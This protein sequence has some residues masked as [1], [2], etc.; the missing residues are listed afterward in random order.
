[1]TCLLIGRL[2]SNCPSIT[3]TQLASSYFALYGPSQFKTIT[4]VVKQILNNFKNKD[5]QQSGPFKERNLFFHILLDSMLKCFNMGDRG[6][7]VRLK[8]LAKKLS[9]NLGSGAMRPKMAERFK[10]FILDAINFAFSDIH[11]FPFFEPMAMF[12]KGYLSPP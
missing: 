4:N 10:A 9:A 7:I 12:L 3:V 1:M 2:I 8:E 6:D 5:A 11:N